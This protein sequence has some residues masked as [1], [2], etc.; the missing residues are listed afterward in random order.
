MNNECPNHAKFVM[1]MNF[2]VYDL[3]TE[4][5]VRNF[6]T[7]D[8]DTYT[9][10]ALNKNITCVTLLLM[11]LHNLKLQTIGFHWAYTV[12]AGYKKLA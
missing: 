4:T 6:Q 2:N 11:F 7:R 3:F 8:D 5:N 9:Q 12:H 10:Y 1:F